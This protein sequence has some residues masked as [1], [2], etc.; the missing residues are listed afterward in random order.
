MTVRIVAKEEGSGESS[1][2]L[3]PAEGTVPTIRPGQ[4]VEIVLENRGDEIHDLHVTTGEHADRSHEE[5]SA[6]ESL[7]DVGPVDPGST[8]RTTVAVPE[9]ETLYLWC[10]LGRDESHGMWMEV[11]VAGS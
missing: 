7:S 4:E 2:C 1:L 10:G 3:E 8:G 6:L 11:P 9:V 5:T